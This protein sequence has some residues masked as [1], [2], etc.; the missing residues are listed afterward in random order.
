LIEMVD[1]LPTIL[2]FCGITIPSTV[3]GRSLAPLIAEGRGKYVPREAVFAENIIPEVINSGRLDMPYE[4]G[5]GVGGILHPDAKMVRTKRWKL[6]Y[7]PG[8]EGELYDLQNDPGETRN[9]IRDPDKQGIAAELKGR[10]L[11]WLITADE[12]DQI[13]PRWLV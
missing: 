7:Y 2:D 12:A 5:K 13:A 8:Y 3:Q 10:L 6:N 1:V 9:L 4:P 11:D